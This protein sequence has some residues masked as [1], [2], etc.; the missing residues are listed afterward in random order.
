MHKFYRLSFVAFLFFS[1]S[2]P[3][4]VVS[5]K[6]DYGLKGDVKK[7]VESEYM[8]TQAGELL[9]FRSV[10]SFS[11]KGVLVENSF[12][13]YGVFTEP[14][15]DSTIM[16]YDEAG[17]PV[18]YQSFQVFGDKIT[19]EYKY[20]GKNVSERLDRLNGDRVVSKL[21]YEYD[22]N[23]K[24]VKKVKE[25][26][27]QFSRTKNKT[28]F[29]YAYH[30]NGKLREKEIRK[31][32]WDGAFLSAEKYTYDNSGFLVGYEKLETTGAV[33]SSEKHLRDPDGVLLEVRIGTPTQPLRRLITFENDKNGNPVSRK[34]VEY[35]GDGQV[36]TEEVVKF[37]Y[38][39]DSAGNWTMKET[40]HPSGS[41]GRV[42]RE[43]G[44]W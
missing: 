17:K 10:Y 32:D 11:N 18:E 1:T 13:D 22:M 26:F 8:V 16:R 37:K 35:E 23:R 27:N 44:Y 5:T 19:S 43:L 33:L 9:G 15:I 12:R 31:T 41:K 6:S 20:V 39:Y 28:V 25:N 34:M 4:Q 7:M 2:L 42:K 36:K 40:R 30:G 38:K 29:G 3:A 24:L 21:T 14:D